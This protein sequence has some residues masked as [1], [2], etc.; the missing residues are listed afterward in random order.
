MLPHYGYLV[1]QCCT[2]YRRPSSYLF[3]GHSQHDHVDYSAAHYRWDLHLSL[4]NSP[5]NRFSVHEED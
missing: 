2:H 4:T 1:N 5:A 3:G